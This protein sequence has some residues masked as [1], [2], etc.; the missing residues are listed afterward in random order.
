[1]LDAIN[2]HPRSL[3][4]IS[5]NNGLQLKGAL[6]PLSQLKHLTAA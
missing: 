3:R 5:K 1:M 4:L 2:L 6:S